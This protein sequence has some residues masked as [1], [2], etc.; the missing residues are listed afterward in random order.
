MSHS[1][2]RRRSLFLLSRSLFNVSRLGFTWLVLPRS[3]L[4]KNGMACRE[5]LET[6]L[7]PPSPQIRYFEMLGSIRSTYPALS[8]T[9]K[10]RLMLAWRIRNPCSYMHDDVVASSR[11]PQSYRPRS[12]SA[13]VLNT[14]DFSKRVT[15]PLQN[16]P[17]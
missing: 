17:H 12:Y 8:G 7:R 15:N 11:Y 13:R 1:L 9:A 5:F 2:L 16:Y 6:Q 4:L 10:R 3:F 14:A